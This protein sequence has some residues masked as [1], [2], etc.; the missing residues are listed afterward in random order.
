MP[1]ILLNERIT[2]VRWSRDGPITGV[3]GRKFTSH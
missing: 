1:H 2:I 3:R